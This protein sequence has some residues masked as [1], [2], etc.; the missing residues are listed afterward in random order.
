MSQFRD[1]A[2]PSPA[3]DYLTAEQVAAEYPV[4]ATTL[5]RRRQ[6][7]GGPAYYSISNRIYYRRADI[8][9]WLESHKVAPAPHRNVPAPRPV[10]E[11]TPP[12]QEPPRRRG[13]PTKAEAARRA[14]AEK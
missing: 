2:S 3:R 6:S 4:S 14:R 11:R 7:G 9:A 1:C 8:E 13:R 5:V 12:R 10:A